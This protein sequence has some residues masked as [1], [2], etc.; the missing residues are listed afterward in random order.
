MSRARVPLERSGVG[1]TGRALVDRFAEAVADAADCLDPPRTIRL[2]AE[3]LAQRL[4]VRVHRSRVTRVVE[5][6]DRSEQLLAR[7]DPPGIGGEV[8]EEVEL[9]GLELAVRADRAAVRLDD[10]LGDREAEPAAAVGTRAISLIEALEDPVEVV[11]GDAFAGVA[12]GERHVTIP[13][14]R[15]EVD[16]TTGGRVL[17]RVVHE[18]REDSR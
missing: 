4:H 9:A 18:V 6:P 8:R 1:R 5:A 11:A 3:P 7:E 17:R 12:D 14:R 16:L 13:A 2:I 15:G 10:V